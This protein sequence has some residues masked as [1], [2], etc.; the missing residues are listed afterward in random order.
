MIE[1]I[2]LEKHGIAIGLD[3]L[4][5]IGVHKLAVCLQVNQ[6]LARQDLPIKS[7]EAGARQALIHLLHLWIRESDPNLRHLTG[8][9]E[10]GDQL[11][12]GAQKGD[13]RHALL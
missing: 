9:E 3:H 5:R 6:A 12:A 10:M 4:H 1:V 11:N 13:I 7:H 2:R 8:R